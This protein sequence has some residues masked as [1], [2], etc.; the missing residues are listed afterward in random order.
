M[1]VSVGSKNPGKSG[2]VRIRETNANEPL[3]TR[4]KVKGA[5]ETKVVLIFWDKLAGS[6]ITGASGSRRVGGVNLVHGFC[7]ELR[8]PFSAMLRERA[9]VVFPQGSRSTE[10]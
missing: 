10:A 3:W 8:E 6:L 7:V 5:V 4:R 1:V 9:Q 2:K